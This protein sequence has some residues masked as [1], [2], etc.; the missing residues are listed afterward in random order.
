MLPGLIERYVRPG[1]LRLEL[2]TLRFIGEDS[3]RGAKAA[4]AAATR[5]RMWNFVELWYRNQGQEESGYATD[6]FVRRIARGAG[7]SPQLELDGIKSPALEP[8]IVVA[9]REATAAGIPLVPG[10]PPGRPRPTRRTGSTDLRCLPR[11]ARP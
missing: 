10:G 5:D 3:V 1:R 7:V 4:E 9:E 6:R 2:R 8:P 11:G